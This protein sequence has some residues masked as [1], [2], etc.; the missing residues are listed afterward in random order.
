MSDLRE[1]LL[2]TAERVAEY[3]GTVRE[4]RVGPEVDV[5]RFRATFGGPFPAEGTDPDRRI[6]G[7]AAGGGGGGDPRNDRRG[8][9]AAGP[10]RGGGRA[11][12]GRPER[13]DRPR[14][15]GPGPRSH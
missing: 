3:R 5:D 11:D 1:L 14:R 10:G 7:L 4:H 15:A 6:G 9:P 13:G 8:A 12:R 2:R